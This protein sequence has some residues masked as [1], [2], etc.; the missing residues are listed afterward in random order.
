VNFD[1]SYYNDGS[2]A[3]GAVLQNHK[4]EAL[5]GRAIPMVNMLS[6]A[7]AEALALL[8]YK[9]AIKKQELLIVMIVDIVC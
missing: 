8:R 4:G 6:A 2:G 7:T 1:A 3:L 9:D 5:A